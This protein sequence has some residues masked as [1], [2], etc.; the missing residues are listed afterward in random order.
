M[1]EMKTYSMNDTVYFKLTPK[2]KEIVEGKYKCIGKQYQIEYYSGEWVRDQLWC[3]FQL[4]G[5]HVWMGSNDI[6]ITDI[7]FDNPLEKE[8]A[9]A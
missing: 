9:D 1:G 8:A 6:L 3:V 7:T 2:G 4:F 5:P